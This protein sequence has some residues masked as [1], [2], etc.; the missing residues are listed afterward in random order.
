[1]PYNQV[2]TYRLA[3]SLE[4]SPLVILTTLNSIPRPHCGRNL[5]LQY[6][7]VLASLLLMISL[8]YHG[9]QICIIQKSVKSSVKDILPY[10]EYVLFDLG[11]LPYIIKSS[12]YAI[13]L[14]KMHFS[15]LALGSKACNCPNLYF[16]SSVKLFIPHVPNSLNWCSNC[17]ILDVERK[18]KH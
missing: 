12:L 1:M 16:N 3:S 2:K 15:A 14:L 9:N 4:H 18:K 7:L 13:Y 10:L 8:S 11:L 5:A 6:M 17:F